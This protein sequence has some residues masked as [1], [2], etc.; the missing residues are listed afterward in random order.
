MK[1]IAA[2]MAAAAV[3]ALPAAV[4]AAETASAQIALDSVS[5]PTYTYTITLTDTGTTNIG[6]FWYAWVPGE[7]FLDS[8]PTSVTDP[9]SWTDNLTGSHNSSDGT[10]IQWLAGSGAALTPGN[11]LAFTFATPDDPAQVDGFSNSHPSTLAGTSFIYSGAPFSDGGFQF[12]VS[13]VPEPTL[14]TAAVAG[15]IVCLRRHRRV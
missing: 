2:I 15:S 1:K 13:P 8:E 7:D 9:T 3:T 5:G 10:A 6:T 12:V 11:S 14:A 4:H